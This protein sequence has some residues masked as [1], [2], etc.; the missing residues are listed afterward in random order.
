MT[1]VRTAPPRPGTATGTATAD[2][3]LADRAVSLC[4][5]L[6]AAGHTGAW[7]GGRL[8]RRRLRRLADM[9]ED[10]AGKSFVLALTDEVLRIRRPARAAA[11]LR[12]LL[13]RRGVPGFVG[14]VDGAMLRAGAAL[15]AL[16]PAAVMRLVAARLRGESSGVILPAEQPQYAAHARRRRAEGVDLNLNVLGEAILGEGEARRRTDAVLERLSWPEVDYV[17]VKI[18][19][20]CSG[21]DVLAFDHHARRIAGRLREL[22]RAA[23]AHAPHKFVNL[24]MEEYRDLALTMAVFTSVL[25]EDEFLTL[26]AGIVLQAYLPDSLA[27]LQSLGEWAAARRARGGAPVKVRLVKGANLAMERVEA[28]LHG[29]PQA[30]FTTKAEVD[31]NFKRLLDVALRPEWADCLRVGVASHN[32]FDVAW[33]LTV[34]DERGA[35]GRIDLE[36]L[37]GMADAHAA[38][39]R[40]AGGG[41]LLY[42]PVAAKD[43]FESTVAYLV[44]RLDENTGEE[45]FLRRLLSL[46]PGSSA[47]GVEEGRFRAAVAA[48]HHDVPA[49]RRTQDRTAEQSAPRTGPVEPFA[50]EPDTDFTIAANRAWVRQHLGQWR[51]RPAADVPAMADRPTVE[52]A[53]AAAVDAAL[54]GTEERRRWLY[55]VAEVM[56]ARR[57]EVVAALVHDA[58]KTV[59]EAD[60]EVSEA[61]DMARYYAE[62]T[63]TLDAL[64]GEGLAFEPYRPVVVASPW[65]FPYAIAAGG[66]L[67]ALAAGSP[68]LFKPAPET[69][70][71]G[72]LLARHCWEAGVPAD[73]LQFVP[74]ADDEAGRALVSHPDVGLIVLTGA[75]ETARL[76]QS[77]RPGLRV[78]AETSGKNAVVV[79]E[80]ADL[81]A[82]VR[83]VTRSAFGYAGQKCSAASL[84]IAEAAVYDDPRFRR[85]LRDAVTS[86]PVGPADDLATVVGPLIHP[87]EAALARA[88]T[89]LEPG[90]EWL[91]EPG[92]VDGNPSLWSPGVKLGVRP[93]SFLHLTECFGPVLGVMRADSLD[94]AIE[95][96]NAT[97]FGLTGGIQSLDGAEIEHWLARVQVGNAYVN[98]GITGAIV[99]RQPF[100]GWKRSA[101]GPGAKAGGPNYVLSLGRWHQADRATQLEGGFAAWW[102]QHFGLDHDPTG[103]AAE[104]NVF[105][106]RPLSRVHVRLQGPDDLWAAE[107]AA[108]AAR[109]AGVAVTFSTQAPAGEIEVVDDAALAQRLSSMALDRL[110]VLGPVADVLREAAA[111]AGVELDDQPVTGHGRVE[112][113]RWVREQTVTR[114]RHRYGNIVSEEVGA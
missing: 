20:L 89:T 70:L 96:Q 60:A 34:A 5:H 55:A 98:R 10:P 35:R 114:S 3:L 1:A 52:R 44:R 74:C 63:H 39:V 95:L 50:N 22:Y 78:H 65:N 57:G 11:R 26:S 66:V 59:G 47:F 99:R 68:V 90:E 12:A 30:P 28:E 37:E 36:M 58:G 75:W 94:H 64:V 76:F 4:A 81:D 21:I 53:V 100:G 113:L 40:A 18:S 93:G 48:R 69:V 91:V 31:A 7:G 83:D 84:L 49:S 107:A 6:L 88:L 82:A 8:A 14:P 86:L 80:A 109:V 19:S 85:Q 101:V 42:A 77:W 15:S 2:D 32:L 25:D 41:L 105:R 23:M 112:L 46:T 51:D 61:I 71:T 43:D 33:A 102:D 16:A 45:N 73:V 54:P 24:D 104:S 97:A 13:R 17:S 27:A 103:L 56:K 110:R 111:D 29:W 38:A 72:L 62:T 9:I 92:M 108:E 67:A 87:P 79:T 106:Y